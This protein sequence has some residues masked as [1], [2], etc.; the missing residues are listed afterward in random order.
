MFYL[1]SKYYYIPVIIEEGV[2]PVVS[3]VTASE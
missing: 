1:G 3:N 2:N